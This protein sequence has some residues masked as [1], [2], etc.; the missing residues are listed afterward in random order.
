MSLA[1][2]QASVVTHL[3]DLHKLSDE[4]AS[5]LINS[6]EDLSGENLGKLLQSEYKVSDFAL[7]TARARAFGLSPFNARGFQADDLSPPLPARPRPF[8][9]PPSTPRGFRADDLPSQNPAR[10]FSREP[11]ALPIAPAGS[12]IIVALAN[13]FNLQVNH[14]IAE[15]TRQKVALLLTLES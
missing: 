7:L 5:T 6:N 11:R 12:Y 1:R 4:Q 2:I 9:P 14:K 15:I 8:A 10:A 13:P 3:K